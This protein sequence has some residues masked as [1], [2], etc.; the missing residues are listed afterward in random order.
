VG[1]TAF[2][3]TVVKRKLQPLLEIEP[4]F[5]VLPVVS[6]IIAATKICRLSHLFQ[7][8][9]IFGDSFWKNLET[10]KKLQC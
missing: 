6:L 1:P 8:V 4:R 7:N 3:D 5:L 2:L 9:E 10:I